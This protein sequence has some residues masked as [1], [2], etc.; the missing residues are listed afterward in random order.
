MAEMK[1]VNRSFDTKSESIQEIKELYNIKKP[2]LIRPRRAVQRYPSAPQHRSPKT[3]INRFLSK[4]NS[5][6]KTNL[7]S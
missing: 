2:T 4:K 7:L 5:C 6:V 1:N 3:L